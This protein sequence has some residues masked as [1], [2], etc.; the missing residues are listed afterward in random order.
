MAAG[1]ICERFVIDEDYRVRFR[2]SRGFGKRNGG[3]QSTYRQCGQYRVT[4]CLLH[5]SR[6]LRAKD[7]KQLHEL[8]R[9]DLTAILVEP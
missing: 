5:D 6:A 1:G 4:G 8:R 3:V 9:L 2:G 7:H